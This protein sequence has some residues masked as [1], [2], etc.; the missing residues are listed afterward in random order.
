MGIDVSWD[1]SGRFPEKTV[2]YWLFEGQWDWNDFSRADKQAYEM[3]LAESHTVHSLIDFR[4]SPNIPRS[5]AI[6]YFTRSAMKAPPNRGT[7]VVVGAPR[8]IR[9]MEGILRA[10]APKASEQYKYT[11]LN[12]IE[13]AYQV[14]E[15]STS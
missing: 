4:A 14:L 6:S 3:A 1:A 13:E 7:V 8:L 10:L 15:H 9:A 11:M 12:D 2:I 5:G